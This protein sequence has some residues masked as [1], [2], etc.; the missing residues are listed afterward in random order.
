MIETVAV[1]G[2]TLLALGLLVWDAL[3]RAMLSQDRR[4]ELALSVTRKQT[5]DD[6]RL[7]VEKR[8]AELEHLQRLNHE[9]I[10]SVIAGT[11]VRAVMNRR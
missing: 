6:L 8:M 1:V 4:A 3:R 7:D 5:L 2:L 11:N 10:E 9:K